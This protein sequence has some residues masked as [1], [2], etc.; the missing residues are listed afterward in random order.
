MYGIGGSRELRSLILLLV[1]TNGFGPGLSVV[2]E[3][4]VPPN[5]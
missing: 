3:G 4:L 5:R 2:A 1:S